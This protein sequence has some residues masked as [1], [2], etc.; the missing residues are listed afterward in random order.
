ML[1]KQFMKKIEQILLDQKSEIINKYTKSENID[2]GSDET[3][4]IQA[5]ILTNIAYSLAAHD[6]NK[7]FKIQTALKKIADGTFGCCEECGEEIAEKRL[8]FNPWFIT[9]IGCAEHL[10][11]ISKK[12]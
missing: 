4:H 3:D 6:K 9:C 12:R 8:T 7:L 5:S 11:M 10:E 1:K 2:V